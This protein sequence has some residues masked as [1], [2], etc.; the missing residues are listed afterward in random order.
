MTV[1]TNSSWKRHNGFKHLSDHKQTNGKMSSLV[2]MCLQSSTAGGSHVRMWESWRRWWILSTRHVRVCWVLCPSKGLW[3]AANCCWCWLPFWYLCRHPQKQKKINALNIAWYLYWR[4]TCTSTCHVSFECS[5]VLQWN[6]HTSYYREWHSTST[7]A[8]IQLLLLRI[9]IV[10]EGIDVRGVVASVCCWCWCCTV[11]R[12]LACFADAWA[13]VSAALASASWCACELNGC[14][15]LLKMAVAVALVR[16][17]FS[18]ARDVSFTIC[19]FA[20]LVTFVPRA[21]DWTGNC[22][23][24]AALRRPSSNDPILTY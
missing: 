23:G 8:I 14:A 18:R 22:D 11:V 19:S 21:A 10:P 17:T 5:S 3:N 2:V 13:L 6:S 15:I 7:S 24:E 9:N 20:V 12:I 4:I 1:S 16:S